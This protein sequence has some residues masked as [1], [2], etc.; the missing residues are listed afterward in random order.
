MFLV[1]SIRDVSGVLTSLYHDESGLLFAFERG[2]GRYY[3][4]TDQVGTPKVVTDNTGAVVKV[5][6]FDSFGR[7]LSDSNPSFELPIGFAGGLEDPDTGLVR[8]GY[9]DFDQASGRWMARDPVLYEGGQANLY[10]YVGNNPVSQ[11]DP[12]GLWCAGVSVYAVFGGGGE[13]CCSNGNCSICSEGGVGEGVD[14]GIGGGDPKDDGTGFFA[15]MGVS[16]GPVGAGLK[17][18][19]NSKC[20]GS[21]VAEGVLGPYK[22]DTSGGAGASEGFGD[23]L[24]SDSQNSKTKGGKCSIQGKAGVRGCGSL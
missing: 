12:M 18:E 21:C 22:V 6:S 23:P 4:A 17:C 8:F 13:L 11:R 5:L 7:R 2:G 9:R 16:C 24:D 15:E 14:A 20:G 19:A 10:L 1:T 3:V